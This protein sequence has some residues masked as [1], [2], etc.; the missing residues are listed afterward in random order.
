VF[1]AFDSNQYN[2]SNITNKEILFHLNLDEE[3]IITKEN[4]KMYLPRPIKS[5]RSFSIRRMKMIKLKVMLIQ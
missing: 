1:T 5:L 2:Y 3:E 4:V